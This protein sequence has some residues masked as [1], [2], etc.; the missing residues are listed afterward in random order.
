[1]VEYW[2]PFLLS[3]FCVETIVISYRKKWFQFLPGYIFSIKFVFLSLEIAFLIYLINS[4][5][6]KKAML[7][8]LI[9]VPIAKIL[10]SVTKK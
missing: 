7:K 3:L 1:M 9:K 5:P 8:F 4:L 10:F 2:S 6:I